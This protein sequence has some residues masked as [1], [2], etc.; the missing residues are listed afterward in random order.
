MFPRGERSPLTIAAP[1]SKFNRYHLDRVEHFNAS[2][3]FL[4]LFNLRNVPALLKS[5]EKFPLMMINVAVDLRSN[6]LSVVVG[7]K[8]ANDVRQI[9]RAIRDNSAS[10]SQLIYYNAFFVARS[11]TAIRLLHF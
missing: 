4:K 5:R 6:S 11:L 9:I 3:A 10:N 2:E 8:A 1:P 7:D